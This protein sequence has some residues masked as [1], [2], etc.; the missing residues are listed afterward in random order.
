MTILNAAFGRD[1]DDAF[2]GDGAAS[3]APL[4]DTIAHWCSRLVGYAALGAA[5]TG[6]LG[7]IF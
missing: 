3:V 5:C 6:V 4:G 7:L 1:K 2:P